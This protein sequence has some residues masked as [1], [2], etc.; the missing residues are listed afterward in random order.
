MLSKNICNFIITT[1][2]KHSLTRKQFAD[3]SGISYSSVN[4]LLSKRKANPAFSSVLKIANNF[5]A[6]IDEILNAAPSHNTELIPLSH[7][8][9]MSNLR[10]Y[11]TS[12]IKKNNITP[13]SLAIKASLAPDSIRDFITRPPKKQT[14]GSHIIC[15]LAKHWE[16]SVDEMIGR[17]EIK[18]EKTHVKPH[19]KSKSFVQ[20]LE[21]QRA[22]STNKSKS[23]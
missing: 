13:R 23:R 19:K 16:V 5:D 21:Q 14:L 3:K 18:Q 2:D 20:R 15:Q 17:V 4:E 10:T 7:E 11:I 22:N 8:K 12:C 9:V 1:L 6:S